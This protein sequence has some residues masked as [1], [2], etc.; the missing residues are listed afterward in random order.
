M[1]PIKKINFIVLCRYLSLIL[2]IISYTPFAWADS[3]NKIKPEP[4]QSYQCI[5]VIQA[6]ERYHY[7]GKKLDNNMSSTILD[8][9]I[10]QLDLAKQ[11]FTLE[12]ISNFKQYQFQLDDDFKRGRLDL[13]FEIFNL[14][15]SRSK[16][17]LEYI[18]SL[19]ETWEK[20]IDLNKQE[21]MIIDNDLLQWQKTK[22]S[23]YPIWKKDLKNSIIAMLLDEQDKASITNTLNRTYSSRLA[24]L[25]QIDSNDIFQ[26]I[27]NTVAASFDPH[28]SFFTPRA[29]EDFDIHMSLSLEGIGAV[30]QN[31]YEYIKVVR[32]IPKGPADKSKLLMPGDKI[33]GVGQGER[34]E[35]KDTIGQRLDRVVKL[36]RGPK[37]SLVRLK[38]IPAKDNNSTKTIQIQRDK[39]KLEEQSAKKDI[40][41]ITNNNKNF[42]IGVIEIPAFYIDFS[43]WHKGDKNYRS[44]TKD[45]RKLLAELKQENIDGLIIDLREN[46]GGSLKEAKQLTGL[47]L[48]SG[49]IVQLKTKHNIMQLYDDNPAI[50]YTSPLIVLINRMSAS[51]SEIF[52]G[53][54]KDYHRGII[55]GTR[56]FG[57]GTVQELKQL[58]KGKLKLTNAKFYRVSG[59]STQNR[60]IIPDLQFPQMYQVEDTGESSLDGALTWDKAGTVLYNSYPTLYLLNKALNYRYK[61]RAQQDPGLR[62]LKKKI[63][64]ASNINSQ[65]SIS[66]NLNTRKSKKEH[67]E[68]LELDIENEY[69]MSLGKT[70]IK[71]LDKKRCRNKRFQRNSNGTC[72]SCYGRSY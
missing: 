54:I 64:I 70:P 23:L 63:K 66:L 15:L 39:V 48:E 41:T 31:E 4:E 61:E 60:G 8:R 55:V 17:R 1:K 18:S 58:G 20:K 30:L 5:K 65:S 13:A 68:Q 22:Q 51:A 44:T 24:R 33:I 14:Y 21:S 62:Y 29:S 37:N 71:D 72:I 56:S 50:E 12:D 69:L 47:F 49:P 26:V 35:I 9:Y 11:L 57:K 52:A 7:L 27:I 28:S 25:L 40:V 43:A 67:Y 2:F 34:G 42:K 53:A 46:S 6:L 45:V 32:L 36:I 3:E 19:I 10:K 38:I 59:E 16:E